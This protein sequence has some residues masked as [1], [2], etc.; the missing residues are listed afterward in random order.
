MTAAWSAGL[1]LGSAADAPA[2]ARR[3]AVV[4]GL[5]RIELREKE[6]PSPGRGE[7]LVR[8]QCA[9]SCGTDLKT[10]RRGHPLFPLPTPIG[11]EFSGVVA[12]LGAG[13]RGFELGQPV[14]AAPTAPCREC[15][16]CRRG[17]ENLCRSA[18]ANMVLGAYG[19]Y[20]LLPRHLVAINVFPKPA[21]ISFERAALL[22]PVS[23]VVH[24]QEL[25]RPQS[26]ETVLVIGAGPFGL[27]HLIV[28]RSYGVQRVAVS[29]RRAARLNWARQLGADLVVDAALPGAADSLRRLNDGYGPDL[30]IECTGEVAGW[31]AA[32]RLVR[33]GG[34]VVLFGGCPAGSSLKIDT[35]RLHYD[36]LTL[37]APFHFR[38]RDVQRARELLCDPRL[39]LERVITERRRLSEI[40]EVFGF[41]EKGDVLKCAVVP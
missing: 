34:R 9:L 40:A 3:Q 6:V 2:F 16:L 26:F 37:L 27:L 23:C 20:L 36:N 13:V 28:L 15:F 39:A 18:I 24:A 5:R 7:M 41:L 25:A 12:A 17:Q 30:V 22:E 33:R 29:G 11:H 19:D 21:Q 4:T 35:R 38:P 10:F 8:V 32:L 1:G 14:M 31:Q